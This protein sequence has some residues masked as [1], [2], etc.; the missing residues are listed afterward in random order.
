MTKY[1]IG[2]VTA[3]WQR[4]AL[5]SVVLAYY[6]SLDIDDLEFVL[7]A[8]G[9]EGEASRTLAESSGWEY[10][11]AP[12]DPLSDKWNAGIGQLRGRV[13]AVLIVGSDDILVAPA[14]RYLVAEMANGADAVN[15]DDLYFYVLAT[16]DLY[17]GE[18]INPGASMLLRASLLDRLDWKAWPIGID[19][20]LDGHLQNRIHTAGRPC[21]YRSISNCREKG[22]VLVDIKTNVNMWSI[23]DMRAMC[24]R[25]TSVPISELDNFLP[26]IRDILNQ[27]IQQNNG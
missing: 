11:E 6:A 2:I 14:I 20:R 5:A 12:N 27:T 24:D 16:N 8:V 1:R 9:S 23:A 18:R 19:R 22:L 26:G 17:Y 10:V 25:I 21:K 4:H 3:L 7:V 13:D 15:L